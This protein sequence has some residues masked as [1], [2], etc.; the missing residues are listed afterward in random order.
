[1]AS[2]ILCGTTARIDPDVLSASIHSILRQRLPPDIQLDLVY[3]ND[4]EDPDA[5]T[6]V[7]RAAG[8]LTIPGHD[9]PQIPYD[10]SGATHA[11]NEQLFDHVAR[12]KDLLIQCAIDD[13]YDGL[14]FVDSDLVVSDDTLWSMISTNRDLVSA[15]F[16]TNWN[17][18]DPSSLGPNVWLQ[19]PYG[20]NGLGMRQPEFW[21]R[22]AQRRITPIA[23]GGACILLNR[24]AL[25]SG[26]RYF[27]RVQ[28]LPDHGMYRGEDRSFSIRAKS[29]HLDQAAD[30]W[31]D[32]FHLYHPEERQPDF[33]RDVQTFIDGDNSHERRPSYGDLINLQIESLDEPSVNVS[34]R[35]RLGGLDLAPELEAVLPDMVTGER[36]ILELF[37]PP[38]WPSRPG[39]QAMIQVTLTS[40]KPYGFPPNLAAVA[41]QGVERT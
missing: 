41:F 14:W 2:K 7:V 40:T 21:R 16:W 36:R 5:V 22:L 4:G 18:T 17:S 34:V 8:G 33:I 19:H 1:M 11:W 26:L 9:R 38:Y 25:D 37:L 23:G 10:T 31:P 39:E 27:P 35:G 3:V 20:Q 15:V 13:N 6:S 24:R 28:N 12:N 32:I 30:P 29:L